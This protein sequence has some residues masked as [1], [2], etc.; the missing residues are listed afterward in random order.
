MTW[1]WPKAVSNG[2]GARHVVA[3]AA[4]PATQA[5]GACPR[6][7]RRARRGAV[8]VS[9]PVPGPCST[10]RPAP[11]ASRRAAG[12]GG[13][14]GP[15]TCSRICGW[16]S[17]PMVPNTAASAPSRGRRRARATACAAAAA[18]AVLGRVARLE[19]EAEAAVVQVDA[20]WSVRPASSRS[21]TRSTGSARRPCGRRR[22]CTGRS[23]RRRRRHGADAASTSIEVD[24]SPRPGGGGRADERRPSAPSCSTSG[25]S[26]PAAIA[27]SI[28]RWAQPASSG[29]AG[30]GSPS[31]IH[32]AASVR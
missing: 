29:S 16:P 2:G 7:R 4:S 8:H 18:R 12:R 28:R 5:A 11:M 14:G 9:K 19:R 24:G 32:A 31:A 26:W 22:P 21:P 6:R 3:A 17:P 30:S 10:Q 1:A 15:A 23:C 27:A 20:A 13:A 25:R